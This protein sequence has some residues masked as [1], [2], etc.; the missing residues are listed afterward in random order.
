MADKQDV[1]EKLAAAAAVSCT[2]YQSVF[3]EN[4]SDVL[5]VT[6]SPKSLK[7]LVRGTSLQSVD[8]RMRFSLVFNDLTILNVL[9]ASEL[10]IVILKPEW[11]HERFGS[12]ATLTVSH[13][14]LHELGIDPHAPKLS[15]GF[16]FPGGK[17]GDDLVRSL[18]PLISSKRLILQPSRTVMFQTKGDKKASFA[19]HDVSQFSS[20]ENWQ[21]TEETAS[22]PVPITQ[23]NENDQE[24]KFFEITVP[25]L[26]NIS[27]RKFSKILLNEHDLISSL[28]V[29]I[30]TAVDS[31]PHE[32]NIDELVRDVVDPKIDMINRRFRSIVNSHSLQIAGT[33]V[34]TVVLAY[35]AASTGGLTATLA[36]I[37]GSGGIGL[38]GK[39][40]A[41]YRKSLREIA[42]DPFYFLWRCKENRTE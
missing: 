32:K 10:S 15:P 7:S 9:S 35:T 39:E 36:T 38:L 25:Y 30:K 14:K 31:T 12:P 16:M 27:F 37:A 13:E 6:G 26:T 41:S 8:E 24:K 19:T 22:P 5:A 23:H 4:I 28:R 33:A 3:M 42:D 29:A 17:E 1:R 34:G 11:F 21:L 40:Y 18:E 20:L 2:E